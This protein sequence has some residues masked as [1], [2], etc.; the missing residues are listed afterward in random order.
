M[1]KPGDDKDFQGLIAE[2][3][4]EQM[5]TNW[6]II[7]EVVDNDSRDLHMGTSDGMTT[8]LGTGML[9]CAKEIMITREIAD[10]DSWNDWEE[11]DGE[12]NS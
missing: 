3:F 1:S 2:A 7:A 11:N 9:E 12:E 5:I 8:W 4:P 10:S 6:I